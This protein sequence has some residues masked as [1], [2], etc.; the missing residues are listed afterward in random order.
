MALSPMRLIQTQREQLLKWNPNLYIILHYS[1]PSQ[2]LY[3]IN[4]YTHESY[5]VKLTFNQKCSFLMRQLP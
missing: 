2:L 4:H 3:V 1:N 5:S